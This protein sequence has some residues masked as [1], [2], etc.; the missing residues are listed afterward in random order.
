MPELLVE[1]E[2]HGRRESNMS[3]LPL[4]VSELCLLSVLI[5]YHRDKEDTDAVYL[6]FLDV[7]HVAV[8]DAK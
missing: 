4:T 7:C 2:A 1:I 3:V 6:P 8:A 5:M